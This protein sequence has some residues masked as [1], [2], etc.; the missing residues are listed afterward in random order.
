MTQFHTLCAARPSVV[1]GQSAR[2]TITPK[3]ANRTKPAMP[4]RAVWTS[5]GLVGAP[6]TMAGSA[7]SGS[8]SSPPTPSS[9]NVVSPPTAVSV[10]KPAVVSMRNWTVAPAASPPGRLS[11]TALPASPAVTTANQPRVRSA[12]RCKAKLQVKE[13]SSAASATVNQIGFS[14][15]SRGQSP[16][17]ATSLG[18]TR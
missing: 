4:S 8:P 13:A 18:S 17:T 6:P 11:V 16:S 2:S 5:P 3:T 14:V 9:E 15:D 1:S 10:S 12:S 7:N